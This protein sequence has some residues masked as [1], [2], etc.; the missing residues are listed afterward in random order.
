[1]AISFKLRK[2]GLAGQ[3]QQWLE[4]I[5]RLD[6]VRL[7]AFNRLSGLPVIFIDQPV[8]VLRALSRTPVAMCIIRPTFGQSCATML[9]AWFSKVAKPLKAY[10]TKISSGAMLKPSEKRAAVVNVVIS[11]S[12]RH[13]GSLQR[14]KISELYRLPLIAFNR[15]F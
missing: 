1:L 14:Q 5:Q 9:L 6:N 3:R 2:Q 7:G 15:I 10:S 12:L 8:Q 13:Q 4:G 11:G